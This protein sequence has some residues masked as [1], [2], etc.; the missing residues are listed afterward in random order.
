MLQ[1][2]IGL[3]GPIGVGKTTL[4]LGL[5]KAQGFISWGFA[6][7]LKR[8][9]IAFVEVQGCSHENALDMFYGKSKEQPSEFFNG[10]TPRWA[11]QT[12]GT[13][14]GR[15]L[16]SLDLWVNA[17]ER[18]VQS[19]GPNAKIVV[20]DVRHLNEAEAIRK[21]GGKIILLQRTSH[22]AGVHSSEQEFMKIAEDA[23]LQNYGTEE[24][25]MENFQKV[26]ERIS[27]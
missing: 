21:L 24:Q 17:W 25:L 8:A 16:I 5:I 14:W 18:A 7:A 26:W 3:V 19:F 2:I 6:T 20:D 27:S 22:T 15:N 23:T 9:L 13:E 11:M 12:F 1:T 4:G 10:K